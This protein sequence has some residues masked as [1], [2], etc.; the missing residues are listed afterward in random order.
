MQ[1]KQQS[2][3]CSRSRFLFK[4]STIHL[5][6]DVHEMRTLR[7]PDPFLACVRIVSFCRSQAGAVAEHDGGVMWCPSTG[8]LQRRELARGGESRVLYDCEDAEALGAASEH[9]QGHRGR[10]GLRPQQTNLPRGSESCQYLSQGAVRTGIYMY[11]DVLLSKEENLGPNWGV[12]TDVLEA[13]ADCSDL[14][15]V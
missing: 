11:C 3:S 15:G 13:S 12:L 7:V 9:S 8:V 10:N 2:P 1:L 6:S 14:D 4:C 5:T